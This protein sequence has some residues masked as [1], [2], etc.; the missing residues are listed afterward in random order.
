MHDRLGPFLVGSKIGISIFL[1]VFRKMNIFLGFDEIEI[2]DFF[3][4]F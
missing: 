3:F 4:F 1:G 2:V